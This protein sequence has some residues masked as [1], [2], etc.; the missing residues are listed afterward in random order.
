DGQVGDSSSTYNSWSPSTTVT[1]YGDAVAVSGG[2]SHTCALLDGG[3]VKC[4]GDDQYGQ[5]GD[6]ATLAD[7]TTP[8]YSAINLGTG[9]T[10]VAISAG[11]YH[12]CALLDNGDVKCWGRDNEGQLGDGGSITSTDYTAA[13]SSTAI[14]LGTGRTA[15]AI[16][17]GEYHTCAILDN[18]DLKC[19]GHDNTGQLGDGGTNTA[20]SAPSSTAVNLGAGRTAVAVKAGTSHTCVILDN[21]DMKCWG[22]DNYG[23]LGNGGSNLDLHV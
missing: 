19:W 6:G 16:S 8:P 20:T 14:N 3:D 11:G 7:R 22:R 4:W 21:G 1:L 9:R 5:L 12:T 17:A 13:P 18:G 15:V 2:R 23:Q 10:A